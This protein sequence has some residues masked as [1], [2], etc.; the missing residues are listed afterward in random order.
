M[1]YRSHDRQLEY[2][3]HGG[4]KD[5]TMFLV[6]IVLQDDQMSS[7]TFCPSEFAVYFIIITKVTFCQVVNLIYSTLWLLRVLSCLS[8]RDDKIQEY[9]GRHSAF[10]P[11]HSKG[12]YCASYSCTHTQYRDTAPNCFIYTILFF[13]LLLTSVV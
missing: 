7:K 12:K 8:D 1:S 10:P 4:G 9:F 3:N 11:I 5:S 6:V 2:T 13:Y